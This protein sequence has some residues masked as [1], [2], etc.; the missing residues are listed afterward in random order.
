[1][2][3]FNPDVLNAPHQAGP[4]APRSETVSFH[5]AVDDIYVQLMEG[6]GRFDVEAVEQG[7]VPKG[8]PSAWHVKIT[9]SIWK[10]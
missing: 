3:R 4:F 10:G 1:M 6:V 2:A 8:M 7:R 5:A 9:P